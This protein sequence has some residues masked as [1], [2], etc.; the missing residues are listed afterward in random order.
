[1]NH[2][3]RDFAEHPMSDTEQIDALLAA[4]RRLQTLVSVERQAPLPARLSAP[5]ANTLREAA[6]ALEEICETLAAT[7]EIWQM[8][9]DPGDFMC[10]TR[11]SESSW[12]IE[13]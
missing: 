5:A 13:P 11:V 2:D 1:L 12:W 8:S 4:A 10:W 6:F 3:D 9:G 7:A